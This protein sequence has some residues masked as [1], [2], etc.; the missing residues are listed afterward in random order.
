[1]DGASLGE[2]ARAEDGVD[3]P[4][5]TRPPPAVVTVP[6]TRINWSFVV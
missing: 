6:D 1:M 5:V 2:H 4:P 3:M